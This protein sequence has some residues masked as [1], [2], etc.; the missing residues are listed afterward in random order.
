MHKRRR[1]AEMAASTIAML[2]SPYAM[3]KGGGP[4]VLLFKKAFFIYTL[5][6]SR[7][8]KCKGF[9]QQYLKLCHAIS[10]KTVLL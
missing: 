5:S 1:R 2:V 6:S 3:T 7:S 8:P 4:H 9:S 10:H